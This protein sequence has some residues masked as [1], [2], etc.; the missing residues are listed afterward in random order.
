MPPK[1]PKFKPAKVSSKR[2]ADVLSESESEAINRQ[3]VAP[4]HRFVFEIFLLLCLIVLS[5]MKILSSLMTMKI[6]MMTLCKLV[7]NFYFL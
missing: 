4:P 3:D 2:K 5:A 6:K 7:E 1:K